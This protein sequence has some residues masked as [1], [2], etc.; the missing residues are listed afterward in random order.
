MLQGDLPQCEL[1]GP[2]PPSLG[3][4]QGPDNHWSSKTRFRE[5]LTSGK[6]RLVT[7]NA[8]VCPPHLHIAKSQVAEGDNRTLV[9]VHRYPVTC[10]AQPHRWL[11]FVNKLPS[12]ADSQ[13]LGRTRSSPAVLTPFPVVARGRY[14]KQHPNPGRGE[15]ALSGLNA[16]SLGRG[17]R[18]PLG[19]PT[20]P[21]EILQP[22][23]AV[24][25]FTSTSAK[26]HGKKWSELFG[27]SVGLWSSRLSCLSVAVFILAE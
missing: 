25:P 27:P 7:S 18:G 9:P 17:P 2:F 16:R 1:A 12:E 8:E 23:V 20:S 21:P 15:P 19:A 24:L 11:P 26:G 4:S 6:S 14:W 10:Q 3:C 13:L 22:Q 5:A